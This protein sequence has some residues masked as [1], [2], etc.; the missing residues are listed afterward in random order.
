MRDRETWAVLMSVV[1]VG[2]EQGPPWQEITDHAIPARWG[3]VAVYDATRDRMLVFA[4]QGADGQERSDVWALALASLR[5]QQVITSAGATPRSD[6]AAVLDPAGDRLIT[7][8][9]REGLTTSISE[10]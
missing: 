2:C 5:W 7:I 8:D 6:L 3:H 4:G 10:A 1:L 9:G